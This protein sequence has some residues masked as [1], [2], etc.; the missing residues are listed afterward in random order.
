MQSKPM[1]KVN[2]PG[3]GWVWKN[4]ISSHGGPPKF[5]PEQRSSQGGAQGQGERTTDDA[6]IKVGR[7]SRRYID[8]PTPGVG[9]VRHVIIETPSEQ[10]CSPQINQHQQFRHETLLVPG[11]YQPPSA[12]QR[13]QP[14]PIESMSHIDNNVNSETQDASSLQPNG[15]DN[16]NGGW[17]VEHPP[18]NSTNSQGHQGQ[19]HLPNS[20]TLRSPKDQ[21][22]PLINS[23][24]HHQTGQETTPIS[25]PI[26]YATQV[27]MVSHPSQTPQNHSH[28]VPVQ[29]H[30]CSPH[31]PQ[32]TV[33]PPILKVPY[34][35][36]LCN[37]GQCCIQLLK[38]KE[39]CIKTL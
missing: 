38:T 39:K 3:T 1:N 9:L 20:S 4:P 17:Q 18:L 19:V 24:Q 27:M 23:T 14:H 25:S 16:N 8:M 22:A 31:H 32:N 15:A 30:L 10:L 6:R 37:A 26:T 36:V 29:G 13:Q 2:L 5:H 33:M 35:P 7:D 11:Q 34:N 21:R 12:T 28:A